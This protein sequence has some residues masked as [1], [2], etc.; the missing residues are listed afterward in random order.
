MEVGGSFATRT[1]SCGSGSVVSLQEVS[2]G[3]LFGPLP[4]VRRLCKSSEAEGTG[5]LRAKERSEIREQ[6][7]ERH[8][9]KNLIT[10]L[11]RLS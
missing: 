9:V 3:L 7:V 10:R 5:I 4:A 8:Q 6:S 1:G 2:I 11:I